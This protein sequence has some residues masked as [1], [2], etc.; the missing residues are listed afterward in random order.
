MSDDVRRMFSRSAITDIGKA[1]NLAMTSVKED[2]SLTGEEAIQM[3][4]LLAHA[5]ASLLELLDGPQAEVIRAFDEAAM[6][7]VVEFNDNF[8]DLREET[9]Q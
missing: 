8:R 4:L 2:R 5:V 3:T 7:F 9:A 6:N 1:S